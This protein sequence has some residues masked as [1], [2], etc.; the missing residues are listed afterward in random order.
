MPSVFQE[1]TSTNLHFLPHIQAIIAS[2]IVWERDEIKP[3][4][5][6][7]GAVNGNNDFDYRP[8][9]CTIKIWEMDSNLG[10]LAPVSF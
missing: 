6:L 2:F 1:L 5:F 10:A 3:D 4:N 9:Y 7:S 8:N